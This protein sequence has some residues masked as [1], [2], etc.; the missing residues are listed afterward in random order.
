MVRHWVNDHEFHVRV[1][2]ECLTQSREVRVKREYLVVIGDDVPLRV[3]CACCHEPGFQSVGCVIFTGANDDLTRGIGVGAIRPRL[4]S[5]QPRRDV[6]RCE[7]L[8][9]SGV[10]DKERQFP[11]CNLACPEPYDVLFHDPIATEESKACW[12]NGCRLTNCD[13]RIEWCSLV[14][15]DHPM[16]EVFEFRL[17]L[18][19]VRIPVFALTTGEVFQRGED[20]I[21]TEMLVA[22]RTCEGGQTAIPLRS[23]DELLRG[24]RCLESSLGLIRS[25]LWEHACWERHDGDVLH[26][27]VKLA[28]RVP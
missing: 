24:V 21:L 26:D 17:F 7:A 20:D 12:W 19:E 1:F 11:D 8:A 10:T 23:G 16:C 18:K 3:V 25:L 13:K 22:K 4:R 27:P 14:L 6:H 9:D 5:R 2:D 28:R 15:R